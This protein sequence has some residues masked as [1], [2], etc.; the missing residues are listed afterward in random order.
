[1]MTVTVKS[2]G[3][4]VAMQEHKA[5]GCVVSSIVYLDNRPVELDVPE[6][7]RLELWVRQERQE[8]ERIILTRTSQNW[9]TVAAFVDKIK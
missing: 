1:M 3:A 8:R 9:G 6:G 7:G 5:N 2:N 4:R